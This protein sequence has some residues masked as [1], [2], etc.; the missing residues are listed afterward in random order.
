LGD[1]QAIIRMVDVL[2]APL[3]P[4]KPKDSP[5]AISKSMLSTATSSPNRLVKPRAQM[6]GSSPDDVADPGAPSDARDCDCTPATLVNRRDALDGK[7][8]DGRVPEA[9]DRAWIAA[10]PKAEVH[11]HLEGCVPSSMAEEGWA[12]SAA[13]DITSLAQLL[14]HLDWSCGRIE[15]ADQLGEIARQV[16]RRAADGGVRHVDVIVNPSHWP[17]WRD[18]LEAMVDALD[19]AFTEAEQDGGPTVGLCVSLSRTFSASQAEEL[20]DQVLLLDRRRVVALSIDG[21]EALG[22]HNERFTA[23]FARAGRFGLHRCAHAGESSGAQGVREAI[24]MLGAERI[25]HGI[26]CAEDPTLV[27]EL[28]ARGVPLDICPTSNVVLGIVADLASHPVDALRRAGVAVSLNTDDPLL[29]GIDL[30]GEYERCAATFEW[31]PDELAEIAR[32]SIESCF[33]GPDR[34]AQML[35]ELDRHMSR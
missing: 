5:G 12:G 29:Y 17:H 25:D 3:G 22:S 8:Q 1:M 14:S 33:A 16:S 35:L 13:P 2:P 27:R 21:N 10:L 18:R 32:T 11:L 6:I 20:L 4:R 15:R 19:G 26:R 31:G 7:R 30:I 9:P 23:T 34:R 28:A 24:D